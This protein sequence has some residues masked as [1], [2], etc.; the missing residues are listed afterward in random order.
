MYNNNERNSHCQFVVIRTSLKSFLNCTGVFLYPSKHSLTHAHTHVSPY[1]RVDAN[2][3]Y[4]VSA[5][6]LLL[7]Y[8]TAH[9]SDAS[10]ASAAWYKR[11]N[12]ISKSFSSTPKTSS[13]HNILQCSSLLNN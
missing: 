8:L 1:Y 5:F 13:L 7:A 3:R 6:R 2:V 11:L 9:F 4:S 12:I 10:A